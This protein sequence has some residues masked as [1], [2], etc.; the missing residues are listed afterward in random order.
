MS[1]TISQALPEAILQFLDERPAPQG[2]SA[3]C[4][5]LKAGK[6]EVSRALDALSAEGALL[7]TKKDKYTTLHRAGVIRGR[8]LARVGAPVFVRPDGGGRDLFLSGGSELVMNGDIVIV[9][10]TQG[11]DRP[12]CDLNCVVRRAVTQLPA[13]IEIETQQSRPK[14]KHKQPPKPHVTAFAYPLD[15]RLCDPIRLRTRS[16][17]GVQS[18]D[19]AMVHIVRYPDGRQEPLGE[20]GTVF[21]REDDLQAIMRAILARNAIEERWSEA[22]LAE[23]AA[24]PDHLTE[25]ELLNRQDMRQWTTFTIDGADAKDFDDAVSLEQK[26]G[27]WQLGV[28]IADVSHYVRPGTALDAAAFERGTSVYLP[29]LTLPMLPERLSN[30][31]CSLRPNEDR[32][33][34]SVLMDV[35]DGEVE[36]WRIT[37]SVIRSRARLTY[38]Q[39]NRMLAG[40]A[41]S[42]VPE[43]LC[44]TLRQMNALKDRLAAR[45][46]ARGAIDLDLPEAQIAVGDGFA[47][48]S[49]ELRT[50]GDSERMIEQFMLSANECVAATARR[51]QLPFAYRVHAAPDAERLP[52]VNELLRAVGVPLRL[53]DDPQPREI[54]AAIEATKD[55]PSAPEIRHA[56]L[57]AM[58]KARYSENPDG[59]Y[60]LAAEDYCHFTSPIRR[61]P[62]LFV[63]R[64]LKRHLAGIKPARADAHAVAE[65]SSER[66]IAAANAER[67]A[68]RALMAAYMARH[69]GQRYEGRISYIAKSALFV[70]LPNT[71]EGALPAR[72]MRERF[73]ADE[74]RRSVVFVHSHRIL[75]LGDAVAVRV[76]N[77]IP[78][79]GEIEFSLSEEQ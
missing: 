11:G 34:L 14:K 75:H 64:M 17:E 40:Q 3:I 74:Q 62:D 4:E 79:T 26:D 60:A 13:F 33:T 54:A 69:I 46:S 5:R 31:L 1:K 18:G 47:P 42:G 76:E 25:A 32:L 73:E 6:S 59:H 23:A 9:T 68:D 16:L 77:A 72:Y 52:A 12:R 29:G 10:P 66:E 63:H 35:R 27:F 53:G 65:Q 20:I 78:A 28:H 50:R 39:V 15:S 48:L 70:A 45:R 57:R 44:E 49:V 67:E 41:D 71:I 8:A 43:E 7:R 51:Q 21:G 37:P 56:L 2:L 61:Y 36:N 19:I 30:G 55:L 38:D 58:S 24:L 22:V